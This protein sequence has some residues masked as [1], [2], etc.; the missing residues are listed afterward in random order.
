MGKRRKERKDEWPLKE[1]STSQE[2]PPKESPNRSY[3]IQSTHPI[4]QVQNLPK[5]QAKPLTQNKHFPKTIWSIILSLILDMI[6]CYSVHSTKVLDQTPSTSLQQVVQNPSNHYGSYQ[7]KSIYQSSHATFASRRSREKMCV[8]I[9]CKVHPRRW[10][11]VHF[12]L[13]EDKA[14]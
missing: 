12:L 4:N 6:Y 14:S 2:E 8:C 13:G 5:S 11:L 7:D 10:G 1:K 3:K 9:Q